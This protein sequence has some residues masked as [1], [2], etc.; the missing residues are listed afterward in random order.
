MQVHN[1]IVL[2]VTHFD[3]VNHS[4]HLAKV[5]PHRRSYLSEQFRI[6]TVNLEE[7]AMGPHKTILLE[8]KTK[9]SN[10]SQLERQVERE[11]LV[12]K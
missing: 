1:P 2:Q 11:G 12:A 10:N 3:T 9:I 7:L 5:L 8:R 6:S 4:V